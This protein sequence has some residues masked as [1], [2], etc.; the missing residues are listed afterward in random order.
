MRFFFEDFS[1]AILLRIIFNGREDICFICG[2]RISDED[3][4]FS[5]NSLCRHTIDF[6]HWNRDPNNL[7]SCHNSCHVRWHNKLSGKRPP[8]DFM[9]YKLLEA[10]TYEEV[11]GNEKAEEY[12]KK[13]SEACSD[14]PRDIKGRFLPKNLDN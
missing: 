7:V 5:G 13:L 11:L 14:Q 10:K 8:E 4:T 12:K 3:S 1:L 6:D 2:K 9:F